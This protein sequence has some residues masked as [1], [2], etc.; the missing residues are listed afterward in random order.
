MD[1]FGLEKWNNMVR[2]SL[3]FVN[4]PRTSI[5]PLNFCLTL[6]EIMRHRI[7]FL[8]TVCRIKELSFNVQF[9]KRYVSPDPT[10]QSLAASDRPT[11]PETSTWKLSKIRKVKPPSKVFDGMFEGFIAMSP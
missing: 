7:G 6:V 8:K 5:L 2:I 1:G 4:N 3:V 10:N 9:G 11:P